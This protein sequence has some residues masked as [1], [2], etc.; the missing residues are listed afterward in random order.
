[1][2]KI[3]FL[4]LKHPWLLFPKLSYLKLTEHIEECYVVH[5]FNFTNWLYIQ[6][7]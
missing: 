7:Y 2:L 1:M 3:K 6:K 4:S 5:C